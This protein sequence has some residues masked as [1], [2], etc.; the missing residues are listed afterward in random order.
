L[1]L[2][3]QRIE[4]KNITIEGVDSCEHLLITGDYDLLQ[5]VMYNL[6]DNAVKFTESGGTIS[7]STLKNHGIVGYSVRNTCIGIPDEELPRIF[8]RFYKSDR[9]RGLDKTGTGLGLYIVKSIINAHGGEITVRS[10]KNEYCDFSFWI[11]EQNL[12]EKSDDL[13]K[14]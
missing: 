11:P 1:F 10:Q 4:Q 14:K 12:N 13:Q 5:Q 8:E 9:S 6:L 7:L 3:E 2:F